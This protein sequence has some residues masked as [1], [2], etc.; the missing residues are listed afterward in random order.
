MK[1]IGQAICCGAIP[2]HGYHN[3]HAY[4]G[5]NERAFGFYCELC[6]KSAGVI[7][8]NLEFAMHHWNRKFQPC[9]V[10][11]KIIVEPKLNAPEGF[12]WAEIRIENL[13]L[14]G[15]TVVDS[16]FIL[17]KTSHDDIC[18]I[19]RNL[20]YII[21]DK[22]LFGDLIL[23]DIYNTEIDLTWLCELKKTS[24]WV[25]RAWSTDKTSWFVLNIYLYGLAQKH[26]VR[27]KEDFKKIKIDIDPK[28]GS[29]LSGI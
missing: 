5:R 2:S 17:F 8:E 12:R 7:G 21:D 27:L 13:F 3:Y 1:L 14:G 4:Q 22:R 26:I 9:D 28:R 15:K 25:N 24:V 20:E 18:G 29:W 11:G 10:N 16:D 6:H 23:K 19:K